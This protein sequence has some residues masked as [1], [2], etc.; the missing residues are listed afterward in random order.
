M[1]P[2][3]AAVVCVMSACNTAAEDYPNRPLR[4]IASYA[5][6]GGTDI[7]ARLIS[8]KLSEALGQSVVVENRPGAG[9]IIGTDIVAKATPDGYTLMV[10]SPSPIVV[11]P[12]LHKRLPYQPLRDLAPVTLITAVP[13]VMAVHPSIPARNV[14]D[15]IKMA[16]NKPQLLNFSSS[17]NGGTGHLAGEM[18]KTM[19]GI[20]MT[21]VPYKGTGPATLA[22]VSGEV[23]LSFGNI[24]SLLPHVKSGKVSA[25]AVTTDKRSPV[26][27]DVP[28]VGETIPGYVAGPWYGVLA[29]GGTPRPII[30]RIHAEVR[31]ILFSADVKSNL[32][33]EGADPIGAG[34]A[35]FAALLKA[36]TERWGK[37]VKQAGITAE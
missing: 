8:V 4:M 31:K 17:G 27:P 18:L 22:L 29:P 24:I 1:R 36:E 28:T 33:G 26:L 5:P 32:S 23:N 37:V 9:G 12:H 25:L 30:A 16:R 14:A 21:H 11:S 35:E 3:A 34:P 19:T 10:A 15:L 2:A 13:A 7:L 6:G 20:T